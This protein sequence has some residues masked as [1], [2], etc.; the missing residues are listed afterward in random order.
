[1]ASD[2]ESAVWSAFEKGVRQR[3]VRK[4]YAIRKFETI[5]D[6]WNQFVRKMVIKKSEYNDSCYRVSISSHACTSSH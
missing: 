4:I 2:V 6:D 5:D 3:R 1:M